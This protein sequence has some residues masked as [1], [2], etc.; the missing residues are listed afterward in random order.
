MKSVL[1]EEDDLSCNICYKPYDCEVRTP[2]VLFCGHTY[3]Q[4]CLRQILN[5]SSNCTCPNCRKNIVATSVDDIIIN[6]FTISLVAKKENR[7]STE[8]A[9]ITKDF[10][11]LSLKNDYSSVRKKDQVPSVGHCEEH[12]CPINFKC[13]NCSQCICGTCA[14]LLHKNCSRI[15]PIAEA[16]DVIKDEGLKR[17]MTVKKKYSDE[18][19]KMDEDLKSLEVKVEAIQWEI[20]EKRSLGMEK[21][22]VYETL[23][24]KEFEIRQMTSIQEVDK[25]TEEL[26]LFL[27][28]LDDYSEKDNTQLVSLQKGYLY[29]YALFMVHSRKFQQ[30]S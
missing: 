25:A 8:E 16:I 9:T 7:L 17:L 14:F 28:K 20:T 21:Y 19:S 13:L 30:G 26:E 11:S 6:H 1:F 12:N 22:K 24:R 10:D 5:D 18:L 15:L 27:G 4:S 29:F 2:R 3:C 23:S